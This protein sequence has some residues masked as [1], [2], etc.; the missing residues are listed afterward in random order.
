MSEFSEPYETFLET[1]QTHEHWKLNPERSTG[2]IEEIIQA[3]ENGKEADYRLEHTE[4]DGTLDGRLPDYTSET[5][6]TLGH[7]EQPLDQS[8][9]RI[10]GEFTEKL[11]E[12]H[13]ETA[14]QHTTEYVSPERHPL[15]IAEIQVSEDFDTQKLDETLETVS[16]L[17]RKVE[18]VHNNI[19]DQV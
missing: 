14:N 17:S 16:E 19:Y 1:V 6:L 7:L 15:L 9:D 5:G 10:T 18:T 8:L 12:T 11:A 2:S 4:T 3:A 13:Y